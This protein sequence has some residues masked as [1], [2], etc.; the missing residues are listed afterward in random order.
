[1]TRVSAV[2]R[3]P[4]LL[5][6][7]WDTV[8]T[9]FNIF[10]LIERK[11]YYIECHKAVCHIVQHEISTYQYL[12]F[13]YGFDSL[14]NSQRQQD[15]NSNHSNLQNMAYSQKYWYYKWGSCLV[16]FFANCILPFKDILPYL[17]ENLV[18]LL[19]QFYIRKMRHST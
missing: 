6:V 5:V 12:H 19:S 7:Y 14:S 4:L 9:Y 8:Y 18:L 16:W 10:Y 3:R 13:H 17:P 1:M 11:K 2:N 15:A